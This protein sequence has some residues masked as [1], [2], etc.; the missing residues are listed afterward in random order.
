MI[1]REILP[2]CVNQH[3]SIIRVDKSK[4]APGYVL[5]YLT[6][7]AVKSYIESFNAGGSRRAITKGHIESFEIP[8][9]P[10]NE[11]YAISD[12]LR[13]LDDKIELNRQMNATLEAM[14][15]A[16]FKSWFVDFD[17]VID[18]ALAAGNPIPEELQSRAA[19]REALGDK[20]KPLPESLQNQFP[21]RFVH[22]EELGWVPEGWEVKAVNQVIT[23]NPTVP[24]RKGTFAK[25]VDMKALPTTGYS[26]Q[27]YVEKQYSGG[28][29][30]Q[31]GDVLV[32]R[33]TPCLENGKTGVVDF[34]QT[35]EAAF[36]STEFIV[37]RPKNE[38]KTPFI[39]C[40]A[41]HEE[42]RLHC[43]QNMIGSSGRQRVETSCFDS[44][45]LPLA[46]EGLLRA[47]NRTAAE[48]FARMTA[49]RIQT[50]TLTRLRDTLLP[51]LLSG[52]LKVGDASRKVEA[53]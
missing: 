32:A 50:N 48:F 20:R 11:Q 52:E 18:N 19:A 8:L 38:I 53:I 37:F 22:T 49:I 13:I 40:L 41:R 1:P 35:N 3:V 27:D 36:G 15:Q 39:A 5:S 14:A 4:A 10:V 46:T 33:I 47:F 9:P 44:F 43:I 21:D 28:A 24:L 17:P 12:I 2:A 16:L 26:I 7:P 25:Y 29:K 31:L 34:L 45:Y 42:F 23:V 6:H 30:F 51:K